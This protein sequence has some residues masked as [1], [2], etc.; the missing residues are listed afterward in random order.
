MLTKSH[1]KHAGG[2]KKEHK[3]E[4]RTETPHKA[5]SASA[6][7]LLRLHLHALFALIHIYIMVAEA[8]RATV[9]KIKH[10]CTSLLSF[11]FKSLLFFLVSC[12]RGGLLLFFRSNRLFLFRNRLCILFRSSQRSILSRRRHAAQSGERL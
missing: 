6:F 8:S 2:K 3:K 4:Q 9:S 5:L 12:F 7:F 11:F 10:H 1:D